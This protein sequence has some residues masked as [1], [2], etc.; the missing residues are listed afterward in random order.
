MKSNVFSNRRAMLLGAIAAVVIFAVIQTFYSLRGPQYAE[1]RDGAVM[2]RPIAKDDG[3]KNTTMAVV[4][5][6][7]GGL[8][9]ARI[10]NRR[11]TKA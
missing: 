6:L 1:S 2:V 9:V 3:V 5:G 8:Y 7:I 4:I 11:S 10:V